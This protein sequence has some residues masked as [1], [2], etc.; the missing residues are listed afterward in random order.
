LPKPLR[1]LKQRPKRPPRRRKSRNR[2]PSWS[3]TRCAATARRRGNRPQGQR[4]GGQR[5]DG[6][7]KGKGGKGKFRGKRDDRPRGKGE[8]FASSKPPRRDKPLD[9]DSPF[10]KLAALKDQMKK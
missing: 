4:H 3:G 1:R 10:A 8:A 5:P 2:S 9:P 6:E 7:H